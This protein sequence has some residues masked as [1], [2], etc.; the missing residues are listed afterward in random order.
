MGSALLFFCGL[1]CK[2]TAFMLIA[3]FSVALFIPLQE[4]EERLSW[5][6]RAFY[7][8]PYLVMTGIYFVMR[9]YS[10]QGIVGTPVPAEGLFSRL[11]LNYWIIPQYI[12]LLLFP[13]DL[14][15][16]HKVLGGGFFSP[17][18]YL[19]AMVGFL[20]V[21]WLAVRSKNRAALFGFA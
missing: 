7:I 10:L 1:L 4:E 8:L 14:T 19:P 3:V 11:A 6:G 16:F 18:W 17:P 2:E 13:N 9:S 15:L 12:G 20:A 5:K 21:I